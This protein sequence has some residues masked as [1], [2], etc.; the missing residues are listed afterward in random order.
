MLQATNNRI[1]G[2]V[3][4]QSGGPEGTGLIEVAL[5]D[6]TITGNVSLQ[7]N[8]GFI[9]IGFTGLD[10]GGNLVG[11]NVSV[12]DSLTNAPDQFHVDNNLVGGNTQINDNAGNG[13]KTVQN[14]LINLT[15]SC[16][17][18]QNPFIGTPN[19]ADKA[20]GQCAP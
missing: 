19:N 6:N 15:L 1:G 4:L 11:G 17:G 12:T 20:E 8:T 2:N 7:R 9:A 10:C 16:F 13:T 18:N 5:C 14:N 3:R